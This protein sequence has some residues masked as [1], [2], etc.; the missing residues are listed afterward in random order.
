MD[1]LFP[2]IFLLVRQPHL[3]NVDPGG[4]MIREEREI[5]G[6]RWDLTRL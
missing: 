5:N 4:L 2:G 6:M 1:Y 3:C